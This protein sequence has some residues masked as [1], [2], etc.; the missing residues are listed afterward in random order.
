MVDSYAFVD[1]RYPPRSPLFTSKPSLGPFFH[2]CSRNHFQMN[3]FFSAC[4]K[5]KRKMLLS[6]NVHRSP[7]SGTIEKHSTAGELSRRGI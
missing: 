1:N 5:K 6:L 7:M 4:P 2:L 3:S